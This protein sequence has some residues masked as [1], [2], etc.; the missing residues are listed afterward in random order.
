MVV[1]LYTAQGCG[2]CGDANAF[3][4]KLAERP[5]LGADTEVVLEAWRAW[6]PDSLRRFRG[7]FAFALADE[8]T[9]DLVATA[10]LIATSP[11][12]G[13]SF[14]RNDGRKRTMTNAAAIHAAASGS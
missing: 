1:E 11:I 10:G 12:R 9:G 8:A 14:G 2:S 7:M 4:A 6:G 3:A 13:R 5:V